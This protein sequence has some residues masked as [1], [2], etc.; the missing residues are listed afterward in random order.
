MPN[1]VEFFFAFLAH[2]VDATDTGQVSRCTITHRVAEPFAANAM[3]VCSLE[4]AKL[5][6]A[7]RNA[8]CCWH[9]AKSVPTLAFL[10]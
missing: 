10:T 2:T 1:G 9:A 7:S 5:C 6:L 4:L 3:A 8:L